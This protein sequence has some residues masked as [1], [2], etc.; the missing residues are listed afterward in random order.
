VTSFFG[1]KGAFFAFYSKTTKRI[2]AI[3]FQ[4]LREN[5]CS[6]EPAL[7]GTAPPFKKCQLQNL[8]KYLIYKSC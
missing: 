5:T 4:D 2:S 8:N 3:V 7:K 6:L 1:S